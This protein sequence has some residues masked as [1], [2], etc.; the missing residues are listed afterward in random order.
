MSKLPPQTIAEADQAMRD[1]SLDLAD[2]VERVKAY[3][4]EGHDPAEVFLSL[5]ANLRQMLVAGRPELVAGTAAIAIMRLAGI[6]ES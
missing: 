4:A 5:L 1:A 6:G 2:S 3:V